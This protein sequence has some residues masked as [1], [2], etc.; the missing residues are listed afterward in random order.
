M[1]PDQ[2]KRLESLL[3][4]IFDAE[5]PA[6]IELEADPE[7]AAEARRLW[8]LHC[9][10]TEEG[11]LSDP[12]TLVRRLA[13]DP[14]AVGAAAEAG[15]DPPVYGA[16]DVLASRF[17]IE[18]FLGAGG[19]G[20]VYLATD[21]RLGARVA[22]KTIRPLLAI[23][24][25]IRERFLVE[26]NAARQVTHPSVCRIYD[27]FEDRDTLFYSMEYVEG[28][29]LDSRLQRTSEGRLPEAAARSIAMQLA[30]GL[31]AAHSNGVVHRDFKPQNIILVS[32]AMAGDGGEV[33]RAVIMDFGLARFV[34][35]SPAG[36][37]LVP[38]ASLQAGTT[39]YMAPELLAGQPATVRTDIYAFGK[40]LEQLLPGSRWAARCVSE[41][42]EQRPE[43]LREFLDAMRGEESTTAPPS[44]PRRWLLFSGLA[45]AAA[46]GGG[47][48][49][50]LGPFDS[51]G[52]RFPLES[53]QRVVLNGFQAA[54]DA[55]PKASI[56]RQLVI[57]A[58]RQSPLLGLIPDDQLL[59][60]LMRLKLPK[61]LPSQLP[62]LFAAAREIKA[63]VVLDCRLERIEK[64]LRVITRAFRPGNPAA[65]FE[66]EHSTNDDRKLVRL[67]EEVAMQLRSEFN[68]SETSLRKSYAPLERV[69]S[70][71]PEAVDLYFRAVREYERQ[72]SEAAVTLLD[73]A[74]LIDP[75]FALA[76][77]Q[78]GLALQT[79]SRS[80]AA[81]EAS[82]RA[83]QLRER[84]T[85]RERN[86][87][88]SQYSS[89]TGD[90]ARY[91]E[92]V[93]KNT[94]LFPEEAVFQ[95]QTA[96]GYCRLN[97]FQDAIPYNERA[98]ELSPFDSNNHSE[99]IVNLA[100]GLA[101][102]RAIVAYQKSR[103]EGVTS[104]VLEWGLVLAHLVAG[105]YAEAHEACTRLGA[106][107]RH[108]RWARLW[109][110]AP[111]VLEGRWVEAAGQLEADLAFD[112]R[113][114]LLTY[115]YYRHSLLGMTHQLLGNRTLALEQARHL[116]DLPA[117][118]PQA[119]FLRLG[120]DLAITLGDSDVARQCLAKVREI[121]KRWPSTHISGLALQ[122]AG[123]LAPD[124]GEALRLL[125]AAVGVWPD[126]LAH[127][128]IASCYGGA[129]RRQE[130]WDSLARCEALRG[131]VIRNHMH[132]LAIHCQVEQARCLALLSRFGEALRL[133][134]YLLARF[135]R[136]SRNAPLVTALRAEREAIRVQK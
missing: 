108:D 118:P 58:L 131:K 86:W 126:P 39:N 24:Q 31:Y 32:S 83:V 12:L 109:Q 94:V 16:G 97:Q 84:V 75:E 67:A 70:A 59:S 44:R 117:R 130:Q 48:V 5:N 10:A 41:N 128:S 134:G 25:E 6:A 46:A 87:I 121:E 115:R 4:R 36:H 1:T 101:P 123:R 42:P 102:A 100:E 66:L 69:T 107:A 125:Q 28:E 116:A 15:L 49:Y 135:E 89:F 63:T 3:D 17:R 96:N 73:Q 56:L 38:Q 11:F 45:A 78:R 22:I 114:G 93:R 55:A 57:A 50:Y 95:R 64:R 43:S 14:E 8:Q 133:Y 76:H 68:E 111:L 82:A 112:V 18:R 85:E 124:P 90:H 37:G 65:V 132:P 27:L 106:V 80:D 30:E 61:D 77:Y 53:R 136:F 26:V 29:S 81:L 127:F 54:A 34:G 2:E 62:N 35:P 19:M 79:L 99:L 129:G 104:P 98:I 72:E 47:A 122:L 103:Q 92:A 9:K 88:D 13:S 119:D 91:L 113:E 33:S 110:I 74:I 20:Q 120:G 71:S 21:S 40:V 23:H 52:A 51:R 60:A 105:N 7:V